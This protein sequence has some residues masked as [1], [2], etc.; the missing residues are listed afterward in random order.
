ME[1]RARARARKLENLVLKGEHHKIPVEDM[2]NPA[3]CVRMPPEAMRDW[4]F[5]A[6]LEN[7]EEV[8]G[9]IDMEGYGSISMGRT[10]A[11]GG[12]HIM[13]R[14]GDFKM[15]LYHTLFFL[16]NECGYRSAINLF[17]DGPT[18]LE[19]ARMYFPGTLQYDGIG[20]FIK[21]KETGIVVNFGGT[22]HDEMR[23]RV[24]YHDFEHFGKPRPHWHKIIPDSLRRSI[25]DL[26]DFFMQPVFFNPEGRIVP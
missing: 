4:T 18:L 26:L 6:G 3:V 11:I 17:G 21:H 5:R 8:V 16:Y 12:R 7:W 23:V 15:P 10:F 20:V 1:T 14:T 19:R 2:K 25:C 22:R 9:E 24:R 13:A